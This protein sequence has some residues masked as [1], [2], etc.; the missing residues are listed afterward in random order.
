METPR[1]RGGRHESG[2]AQVRTSRGEFALVLDGGAWQRGSMLAQI[3]EIP[4]VRPCAVPLCLDNRGAGV[5][6]DGD[7]ACLVAVEEVG[8]ILAH[9]KA[10]QQ[11]LMQ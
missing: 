9:S 1:A 4:P 11:R 10:T 8:F 3:S 2:R 5:I 7:R 6:G